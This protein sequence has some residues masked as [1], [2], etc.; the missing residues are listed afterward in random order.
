MRVVVGVGVGRREV[1]PLEHGHEA[2]VDA[3]VLLLRLHHPHALAPHAVH[4]AED[5][6]VLRVRR[7]LYTH[8]HTGQYSIV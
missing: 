1:L 7:Q 5:V 2:L 4:H 6:Q 8:T 3:D